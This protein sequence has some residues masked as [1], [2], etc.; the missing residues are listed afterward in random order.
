MSLDIGI[1]IGGTNVRLGV[2]DSTGRVVARRRLLT[3]AESGPD[4]ALDRIAGAVEALR[5][6]RQVASIGVGIAGLVDHVHGV[7]RVPPNLRGWHGTEV[8][9]LLE[10]RTQLPVRCTNDANAVTLGEWLF[11][12]GAGCR[13]LFCMTLGTGVGGGAIVGGRL[14]L[15]RNQAAGEVGHTVIFGNGLPCRCGGRGCLERY[16]GAD[17]IVKRARQRVKVQIRRLRDHKHQLAMFP[18]VRVEQP[19]ML[20]DMLGPRLRNLSTKE[21]G[22]AARSR[23]PL[24]LEL[25]EE[26][27]HYVGLA[28]VNVVALLDPERIVGG[29]GVSGFGPPLLKSIRKTV[30]RRGQVFDGRQL[31]IVS[32]QLGDDAGILGASRLAGNLPSSG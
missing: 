8:K 31:E 10:E 13:D 28:L 30:F 25:V 4:Q 5:K 22:K 12:A 18:G 3:K 24:S 27:G 6:G 20:I 1:D 9:R 15:G 26:V 29:G 32:A 7:V 16:V 23:D 21:I 19:S 17:R 14:L 2:V 11:G